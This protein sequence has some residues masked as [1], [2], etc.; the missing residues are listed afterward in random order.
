MGHKTNSTYATDF[1]VA[2]SY[3]ICSMF[4]VGLKMW[5]GLSFVNPQGRG[6]ETELFYPALAGVSFTFHR[7]IRPRQKYEISTRI[8][9]WDD[10]WLYLISHFVE[11]GACKPAYF[12]DRK[13]PQH[14]PELNLEVLGYS[15]SF[16]Y[17]NGSQ[18]SV[19][20]TG[21]AKMVFKKGRK[22]IPP[23]QFLSDCGL[24]PQQG[25]D[26]AHLPDNNCKEKVGLDD[27]EL[28][29]LKESIE[30]RRAMGYQ[31]AQHLNN[32]D[33]GSSVFNVAEKIFYS[34]A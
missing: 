12:S 25:S 15:Q 19:F 23:S 24:L 11:R 32:L 14:D 27:E 30:V 10:K 18:S 21:M 4:R 28:T 2:R 13:K 29:K 6:D 8:L 26:A 33:K 31:V 3:H 1:D 22:T 5:S 16:D 17:E 9:S 34:R 20:A 7:A